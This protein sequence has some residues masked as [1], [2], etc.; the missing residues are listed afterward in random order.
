MIQPIIERSYLVE[1]N[2]GTIAA[3][4]KINFQYIPQL[5]GAEIYGIQSFTTAQLGTSPNNSP[6]ISGAGSTS[7]IVNFF[8]QDDEQVFQM[9]IADLNSELLSGFV[10]LFDN[11]KIN[12]TKSFITI[13]CSND[14]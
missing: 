1:V 4:R 8:V 7:I 6:V 2:L 10:R 14:R 11:K 5:E 9:P 13:F 12:I 3:G